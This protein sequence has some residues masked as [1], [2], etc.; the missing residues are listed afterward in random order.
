MLLGGALLT[1]VLANLAFVPFDLHVLAWIAFAPLFY[2]IGR[3]SPRGAFWLGFS[4]AMVFYLWGAWW[5]T[6]AMIQF[7]GMP[8]AL[9]LLCLLAFAIYHALLYG[10]FALAARVCLDR[11]LSPFLVFPFLLPAFVYFYPSLFPWSPGT[12]LIANER[13]AQ[14]A[15]LFGLRGLDVAL[16]AINVCFAEIF[17]ILIQKPRPRATG[18][19]VALASAAGAA[20]LALHVYGEFRIRAVEAAPVRQRINVAIVQGNLGIDMVGSDEFTLRSIEVYTR[21][22][23]QS[24][25]FDLIVWPESPN[26]FGYA[27]DP[28]Y[29]EM[30]DKLSRETGASLIFGSWDRRVVDGE[31]KL[32]STAFLIGPGREYQVYDK[33]KLL[34]FGDYMPLESLFPFL[35]NFVEGVGVQVPGTEPKILSMGE[36][37]LAPTICYEMLMPDLHR[38]MKK[39]GADLVVNMT[40]D[41]WFGPTKESAQH[42]GLGRLRAIETRMPIVRSTNTGVSAFISPTG[43]VLSELGQDVEGVLTGEIEIKDVATLYV[44]WGEIPFWIYLLLCSVLLQRG[45]RSGGKPGGKKA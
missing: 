29:R 31:E 8:F 15:D 39:M 25:G 16:I 22:T 44:A 20:I 17:R 11:A 24:P 40:N 9:A 19:I 36:I 34:P 10:L 7:G 27:V 26:P 41:A 30:M 21:L 2:A 4:A 42:M 5:I 37:A 1:G 33:I 35:R 45:L 3:S 14:A 23:L 43:R 28:G 32:Y 12:T 13:V 38:T 6:F 18:R